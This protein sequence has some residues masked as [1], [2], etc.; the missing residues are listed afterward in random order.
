MANLKHDPIMADIV[1]AAK[2]GYFERWER[3]GPSEGYATPV[4][5]LH[6]RC[7]SMTPEHRKAYIQSLSF[8]RGTVSLSSNQRSKRSRLWLSRSA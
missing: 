8:A 1:H 4:E 6:E 2:I 3:E 5:V 7:R